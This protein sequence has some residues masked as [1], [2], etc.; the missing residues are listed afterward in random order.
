VQFALNGAARAASGPTKADLVCDGIFGPLTLARVKDHQQRASLAPDGIVGPLTLDTLFTK[1]RLRSMVQINRTDM[2]SQTPLQ[3]TPPFLAARPLRSYQPKPAPLRLDPPGVPRPPRPYP[4][5]STWL[6]PSLAEL[7][8]QQKAFRKWWEQPHPK[9]PLPAPL[10]YP[11]TIRWDLV[12]A[13]YDWVLPVPSQVV[14]V[15]REPVPTAR[16]SIPVF[17]TGTELTVRV[18]TEYKHGLPKPKW[19]WFEL[20]VELEAPVLKTRFG[21]LK[22]SRSLSVSREHNSVGFTIKS[23]LTLEE[24]KL[25]LWDLY[26]DVG[27]FSKGALTFTGEIATAIAL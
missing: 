16:R 13:R 1:A 11:P 18:E 17:N 12:F 24:R 9:P 19:K 27:L 21:E 25:K 26:G 14:V 5:L 23:T 20:E 6:S 15:P 7:A 10:P 3:P 8:R 4:D 22:A 2:A